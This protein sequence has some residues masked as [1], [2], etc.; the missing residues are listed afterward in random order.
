MKLGLFTIIAAI[1]LLV[2]GVNAQVTN[3]TVK[4]AVVVT[5]SPGITFSGVTYGSYGMTS[6]QFGG[7][8]AVVYPVTPHVVT[9]VRVQYFNSQLA[10]PQISVQLQ[11]TE[12]IWGHTITPFIIT[13]AAVP[14]GSSGSGS[15]V[16]ITGVGADIQIYKNFSLITDYEI[17]SGGDS[18]RVI[19][20]GLR[21]PF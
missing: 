13:A 6:K 18:D 15:V 3:T 21:F 5:N 11:A 19:N 4:P 8:I 14:I 16:G 12:N 2:S 9:G 17:W 7:G 20:F 1:L 10:I